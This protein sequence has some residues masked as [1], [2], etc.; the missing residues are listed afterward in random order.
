M[1]ELTVIGGLVVVACIVEFSKTFG[2]DFQT[3]LWVLCY[4][5]LF[6]FTVYVL[7]EYLYIK[8]AT[9]L[10]LMVAGFLTCWL[11]A[12]DFW[13][14]NEMRSLGQYAYGANRV[15]WYAN[16][17]YQIGIGI[18]IIVGGYAALYYLEQEQ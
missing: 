3:S 2:L 9:I 12:Y 6:A 7:T 17:W 4:L 1:K 11:P 16:G 13:S 8:I 10:P 14:I 18:L 5:V 15:M